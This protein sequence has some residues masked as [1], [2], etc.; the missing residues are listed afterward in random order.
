M[1]AP[2]FAICDATADL[3]FS[4]S[5]TPDPSIDWQQQQQHLMSRFFRSASDSESDSE[6]SD[7]ESF[8]SDE[9]LSSSEEESSEEEIEQ[10]QQPKKSRFLKG[11][12]SDSDEDSDEEFGR[13]RQVKSAKDKQLDEMQNSIR[14]I[15]NGQKNND[16]GLIS[17]G[18]YLSATYT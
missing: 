16:W 11:A 18:I 13:K 8:I 5:F 14:A 12:G 15:E 3:F 7:N 9:E 4:R 1:Q 6:T 2:N 10:E 17:N